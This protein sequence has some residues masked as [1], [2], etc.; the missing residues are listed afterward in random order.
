MDYKKQLL[1]LVD[2]LLAGELTVPQFRVAYYDFYLDEVPDE[3]L[4]IQDSEF[5]GLVQEML[6]WTAL[7]PPEED[8]AVGWMSY[9]EFRDWVAGERLRYQF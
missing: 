3:A 6:D 9:D 1:A 8:R 5:F 4:T 7:A 2:Q